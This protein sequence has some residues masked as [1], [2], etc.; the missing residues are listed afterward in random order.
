[1]EMDTLL[2]PTWRTKLSTLFGSSYTS[3]DEGQKPGGSNVQSGTLEPT[4]PG[5]NKDW[6]VEQYQVELE[7]FH[8]RLLEYIRRLA[9]AI[10]AARKVEQSGGTIT[11]VRYNATTHHFEEE[12]NGSWQQTSGD[13]PVLMPTVAD[14]VSF[15]GYVNVYALESTTVSVTVHNTG[16]GT[17]GT[18]DP[19]W[20]VN[21]GTGPYIQGTNPDGS[22]VVAPSGSK[23]ISVNSAHTATN[24]TQDYSTIVVVSAGVNLATL[25]LHFDIATDNEL[26]DVLVN[27]VS[28]SVSVGNG[29]FGVMTTRFIIGTNF[30]QGNN[31]VVFRTKDTGGIEGL[32]VEWAT[33]TW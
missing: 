20:T 8:R 9:M 11:G 23:W 13:Q 3:D 1:M 28:Q 22:W 32:L 18:V 15:E 6:T 25:D 4:L 2:V 27:G 5:F 14:N 12:I 17:N 19:N 33:P 7:S 16:I 31:T 26:L 21:A 10:A 24:A 30:V 29:S